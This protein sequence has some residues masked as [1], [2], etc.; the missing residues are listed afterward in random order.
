MSRHSYKWTSTYLYIKWEGLSPSLYVYF[1]SGTKKPLHCQMAPFSSYIPKVSII[2]ERL[3]YILNLL[4]TN[5]TSCSHLWGQIF[6]LLAFLSQLP[7]DKISNT[8]YDTPFKLTLSF[9]WLLPLSEP[10]LLAVPLTLPVMSLALQTWTWWQH[11]IE[12]CAYSIERNLSLT[13]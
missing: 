5:Y 12:H 6:V 3:H 1:S 10:L 13:S 2:D 4:G 8:R 7:T 11:G 9:N